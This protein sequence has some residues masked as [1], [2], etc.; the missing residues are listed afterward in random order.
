[1]QKQKFYWTLVILF[2][3]ISLILPFIPKKAYAASEAFYWFNDNTGSGANSGGGY[4][5]IC[6]TDQGSAQPCINWS[7]TD[8]TSPPNGANT[9]VFSDTS[10]QTGNKFEPVFNSPASLV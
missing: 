7:N 10:G 2:F 8:E 9:V 1:M 4:E 3:S 6:E 5:S